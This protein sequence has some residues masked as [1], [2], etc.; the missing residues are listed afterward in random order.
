VAFGFFGIE[1][2]HMYE[3]H[4]LLDQLFWRFTQRYGIS[5]KIYEPRIR[6]FVAEREELKDDMAGVNCVFRTGR[7]THANM[8]QSFLVQEKGRSILY[9]KDEEERAIHTSR[10]EAQ[11]ANMFGSSSLF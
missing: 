9:D 4:Q 6:A 5:S 8:L 1:E 3:I 10:G 11:E 7:R 2:S